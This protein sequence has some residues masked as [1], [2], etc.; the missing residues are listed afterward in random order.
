MDLRA[1]RT[2]LLVVVGLIIGYASY[3]DETLGTAIGVAA[4][5]VSVLYVVI[6][7]GED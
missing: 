1:I 5:A 2:I 6:K 3:R 4:G 7:D